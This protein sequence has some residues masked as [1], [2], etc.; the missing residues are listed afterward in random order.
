MNIVTTQY[1]LSTNSLEIFVAGCRAPHCKGC[2]NPE[3][4]DFNQGVDYQKELIKI[5]NKIKNFDSLI[6]N[7]IIVGGEPLDQSH[8]CLVILLNKLNKFNKNIFLFTRYELNNVPEYISE[9]CDYIKCGRYIP[10]LKIEDN[11][12]YGIKLATSNQKIFKSGKDF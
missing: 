8:V 11:V 10:S 5:E 7:I 4:W 1:T 9:L 12:Q 3:L 6:K 2:C